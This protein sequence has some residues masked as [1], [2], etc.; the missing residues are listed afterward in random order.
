MNKR[1]NNL[2]DRF[3]EAKEIIRVLLDERRYL[4]RKTLKDMISASTTGAMIVM[5]KKVVRELDRNSS[6]A[7][8][9]QYRL[10]SEL[11]KENQDTEYGRK[12]NFCDIRTLE[13][14]REKV[15]FTT[16]DDYEPYIERMMKGE[17]NLLSAREPIHFALT[18]GSIGVPKYIP[19]S[20]KEL[21]KGSKYSVAMAFGVANE[22]YMNTTGRGLPTG[23]GLNAIELKVVKTESGVD[24]GNLSSSLLKSMRDYIPY[25]LISPW[26]VICPEGEM[27]LRYLKARLA[28]GQRDMVFMDS[29]FMTGLVDIM[30]Y[31]REN[32]EMLC[33]DIYHGRISKKVRVPD[34]VRAALT[35]QLTPDPGRAK[36]LLRE[37]REGFDTPIIPRIWPR[38]SWIGGI[39][40][41][42]FFPYA[43][44]MRKYTGKSIPFNNLCYAASESLIA[45]A[46][47]MG[48]E[49]Y[50]LIPD[51]GFYEF[52]PVGST[53]DH[54]LTIEE[55][56]IGEDY[57]IIVTNLSGFYR[58]RLQDV[59]RVTGYYNEA[60]MIRFIYRK[61]QLLSIAGEKTNEES[62]RWAVDAFSRAVSVNV[63]DYS[64]FAD[65]SSSP[66]HYILLVEPDHIVPEERIPHC[67]DVLEAKLMQA[68]PIYSEC[69]HNGS[70]APMEL[71]FLQ[72]QTYQLYRDVMIMKG[73]SANQLKPVRVIDTPV[74][75]KFFFAMREPY[76][77]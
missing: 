72:Q 7:V 32:Y 59:V 69:I 50:V 39:G 66:G 62:V 6:Q 38:M 35:K 55:L 30:D 53:D 4:R 46:R 37:F 27:D 64:V 1:K 22:Y 51:G 48:D 13:D 76:E 8:I 34:H 2:N 17:Q 33:R 52:I 28:L 10:L 21:K 70:L 40:T 41:G 23:Q 44:R 11:M 12:Y 26:E 18:S 3:L 20:E 65:T 67:R 36:E 61:D 71:V 63:N 49:S 25:L 73:A 5:G 16:Y 9:L 24:Q 29:V 43:K 15:P 45:A 68:N 56:E 42:G 74:K 54:T 14:F 58:Y 77:D 60:P 47:H 19:V 57:E 75:E 31:I